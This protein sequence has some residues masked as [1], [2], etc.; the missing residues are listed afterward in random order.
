MP[1]SEDEVKRRVSVFSEALREGGR[2]L[3]HQRMEVAREI[4][5]SDTHPDVET[6]YQGV[7]ERVP[8]VSLDTV[9]RTLAALEDMRLV[10]RV[11]A[12]AGPTRYDANLDRHH[13]FVCMRCGLIRDLQDPVLDGVTAPEQTIDLGRVESVKVQFLGICKE[14]ERKG[15]ST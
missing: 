6:I 15:E 8:T 11:N 5:R 9:Y 3:T 1:I 7:R 13:H 10:N 2:R 4:A 12:I 14:C